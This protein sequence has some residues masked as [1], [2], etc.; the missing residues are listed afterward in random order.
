MIDF[1][2]SPQYFDT[3]SCWCQHLFST[4][5][6]QHAPNATRRL[7]FL[8]FHLH[9]SSAC[10][11]SLISWWVTA[12]RTASPQ[13]LK[14]GPVSV[15][16][17]SLQLGTQE[18]PNGLPV[19]PVGPWVCCHRCCLLSRC[20]QTAR[21]K[22]SG[23]RQRFPRVEPKHRPWAAPNA[24]PN[25]SSLGPQRAAD[26]RRPFIT[27]DEEADPLGG[28][29]SKLKTQFCP[30]SWLLVGIWGREKSC[31]HMTGLRVI[32]A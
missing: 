9:D 6:Y 11:H 15:D 23:W 12:C 26:E 8:V 4:N 5:R 25:A 16:K 18:V 2:P 32:V 24:V 22:R 13:L 14:R 1:C 17:G 28:D 19:F 31:F 27:A 10:F 20:W 7:S 3:E 30:C 29:C 21:W